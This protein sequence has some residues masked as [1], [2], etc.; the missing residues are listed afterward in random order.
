METK[1]PEMTQEFFYNLSEFMLENT[2][3]SWYTNGVL[4]EM[5]E[6]FKLEYLDYYQREDEE[7]ENET[8]K[9]E[10][11]RTW[12]GDQTDFEKSWGTI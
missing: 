1:K 7:A 12:S 3:D 5:A 10:T 8:S 4:I 11:T 6:L 9:E 2:N